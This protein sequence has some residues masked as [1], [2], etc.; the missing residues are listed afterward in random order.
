M[1]PLKLDEAIYLYYILSPYLPDMD[2]N[3]SDIDLVDFT[4][5]IIENI[6]ESG[7]HKDYLLIL[8]LISQQSQEDLKLLE[9][10]ET[11]NILME[12]FLLNNIFD[13][14]TFCEFIHGSTKQRI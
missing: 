7:N 13:L 3:N 9:G 2:Y 5:L 10:Y 8:E 12:G 6:I 1:R 4:K 14:I 11:L